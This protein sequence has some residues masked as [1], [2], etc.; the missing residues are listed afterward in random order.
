MIAY[1]F[2]EDARQL[3]QSVQSR[4]QLTP[5]TWVYGDNYNLQI[6]ITRSGVIQALNAGDALA[7]LVFQP[8]AVLPASNLIVVSSPQ[9]L[10]DASGNQYYQVNVNL[11]TTQLAAIT[12]TPNTPAPVELHL[13][14]TPADGERF[15]MSADIQVTVNPDPLQGASGATSV[16]PG[17]P[18]SPSVFEMIANKGVAGGY[19]GLDGNAHLNPNQIPTDATL[20]VTGG[21]LH[22]IGSG[23][24]TGNPY[25]ATIPAAFTI[26]AFGANVTVTMGAAVADMVAGQGILIT[27]GVSSI[28]AIIKT[29]SGTALTVENTGPS[30]SGTMN[31]NSHVY[32]GNSAAVVSTAL[33]GL[34]PALPTTTPGKEFFRGDATYAQANY[35]DLTNVPP[36]FPPSPHA[37]QHVTGGN[38]VIS[39]GSPSA[40]GLMPPI[41]NSSITIIGG[42]LQANVT[43][44]GGNS[45]VSTITGSPAIPAFGASATFTL[46]TAWAGFRAGESCVI[47]DGLQ[48]MN[49]IITTYVS[50]PPTLTVRNLGTPGT[51]ISGN[52][53]A[54]AYVFMGG[55]PD[56][57]TIGAPGIVSVDNLTIGLNGAQL[58]SKVNPFVAIVSGAQAIPAAGATATYTLT[59]VQPIDFVAG[60]SILITDGLKFVNGIVTVWTSGSNQLTFRNIGNGGSTGSFTG[61]T[62]VYLGNCADLAVQGAVG[63]GKP[64][65]VQPDGTTLTISGGVL[66][67][68]SVGLGFHGCKVI[69]TASQTITNGNPA[70][71][72]QTLITDASTW[73]VSGTPGQITVPAGQA[74]TYLI[75]ASIAFPAPTQAGYLWPYIATSGGTVSIC[76][77]EMSF[78]AAQG[79]VVVLNMST[80]YTLAAGANV[81]LMVSFTALTGTIT[82]PT[83][84]ANGGFPSLWLYRIA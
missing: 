6:Y 77:G 57:A 61:T 27:D 68:S 39:L 17:Y 1:Y 63:T 41:D 50:S 69:N 55:A 78:S 83:G 15:S 59:N 74:G 25:V 84:G 13:T 14:F 10:T 67:S 12:Q 82:L 29:V 40:A 16:P 32:M 72:S 34:V 26:P 52:F 58:I 22:A 66:S 79:S 73:W 28:N 3:V 20:T 36:N 23:G 64:G 31:A 51:S 45:W 60:Q 47:T 2:D 62:H 42:K 8:P 70:V 37:I 80:M 7:I 43:G 5:Q 19:A 11:K 33:P 38:D 76:S 56:I 48:V 35:P 49:G 46:A 71:F 81:S 54:T 9:V 53:A 18:A 30:V 44:A 75:G 65:L 4:V 24:G 21:Q